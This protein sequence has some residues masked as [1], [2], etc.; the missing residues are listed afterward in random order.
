MN[1][2]IEREFKEKW[3]AA[4]RSDEYRQIKSRLGDGLNG[5]CCLGVAADVAGVHNYLP[6]DY[7]EG[8]GERAARRVHRM[9]EDFGYFAKDYPTGRVPLSD[10]VKADFPTDDMLVRMGGLDNQDAI[11][12]AQMNDEG[13]SFL[14]I[15]DY[16]AEKL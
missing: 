9:Y 3:L 4:L 1:I 12:L 10:Q 14:E 8:N 5:R 15:A 6:E 2:K 7:I 11:G 13:S 16:I